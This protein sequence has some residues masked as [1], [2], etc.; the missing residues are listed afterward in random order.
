MGHEEPVTTRFSIWHAI[1]A[2]VS[3]GSIAAPAWT[4]PCDLLDRNVTLQEVSTACGPPEGFVRCR[5]LLGALGELKNPSTEER[6]ALGLGTYHLAYAMGDAELKES[7]RRELA[8]L[9]SERPDNV[10]VVYAL[11]VSFAEE[12]SSAIPLMRRVVELDPRCVKVMFH[13]SRYLDTD[14]DPDQAREYRRLLDGLYEHAPASWRLYHAARKYETHI[15]DGQTEVAERFRSQVVDDMNLATLPVD[16]ANRKASLEIACGDYAFELRFEEFCLRVIEALVQ[17][18]RDAGLGFSANLGANLGNFAKQMLFV[19]GTDC[20]DADRRV[21][22]PR[23]VGVKGIEYAIRVRDL[24]DSEPDAGRNA[25]FHMAYA[26]TVGPGRKVRELRKAWRFDRANG[27]VGLR[28]AD[29]LKDQGRHD[30]AIDAYRTVI[31]NDDGRACFEWDSGSCTPLAQRRLLELE[32]LSASD[33][34]GP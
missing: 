23:C 8:A 21:G 27:A 32:N 19:R 3:T 5:T 18:D 17:R 12:P 10:V 20:A 25:A 24:L 30:E 4:S 11:A 33:T 26:E 2:V 6:V 14:D 1:A 7:A 13:L 28:V 31:A 22:Q 34:L 9:A 15:H 29:A 16:D